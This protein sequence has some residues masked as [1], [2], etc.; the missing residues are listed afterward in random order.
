MHRLIENRWKNRPNKTSDEDIRRTKKGS[1]F[2]CG[3]GN[4]Y[5]TSCVDTPQQNG[6]VDRKNRHWLNVTRALRFQVSL[7]IR[8]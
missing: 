4:C 5:E 7:P 8:F 6:R 1:K 2:F 3:K